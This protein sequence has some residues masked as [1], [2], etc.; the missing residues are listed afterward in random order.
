MTT[1]QVEPESPVLTER[2]RE[3]AETHWEAIVVG[4]LVFAAII[5]TAIVVV[6]HI[7]RKRRRT[8]LRRVVDYLEDLGGHRGHL[9]R[10]LK[11]LV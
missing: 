6:R 9:E 1:E 7:R 4:A 10:L 5:G 8:L 11:D 2:V 3:T